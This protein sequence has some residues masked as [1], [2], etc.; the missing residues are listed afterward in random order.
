MILGGLAIGVVQVVGTVKASAAGSPNLTVTKTGDAQTLLGAP[1]AYSIK[2]CN[3]SGPD[4]FNGSIRDVLP[5]GV[6]LVSGTPAPTSV[7]TDAPGAGQ[8]TLLWDNY[9]DLPTGSCMSVS[10]TALAD[11]TAHPVGDTVT[12]TAN[13]YVNTNV[14]N[15]VKFDASGNPIASSYTGSGTDATATTGITAY[16]LTK[17]GP[18]EFMRG[19]HLESQLYTLTLANNP[20]TPTDSFVVDDYLPPNLELLGCKAG[21]NTTVAAEYTGAVAL[22]GAVCTYTGPLTVSSV[23]VETI[24]NTGLSLTALGNATGPFTPGTTHVRW[25]FA[26]S[27]PGGG[28]QTITYR[29]GIP[30]FE[31][32]PFTGVIP[33]IASGNQSTNL[34]NNTGSETNESATEPAVVNRSYSSGVYSGPIKAPTSNPLLNAASSTASA[35]DFAIQKTTAG[36][37]VQ[38]AVITN[39]FSMQVSEYRQIASS[40][41]TDTLPDGQCPLGRTPAADP[42]CPYVAADVPTISV[43]GAAPIAAPYTSALETTTGANPANGSYILVWDKSTV[44]SLTLLPPDAKI[45][46]VFKSKVR[47]TYR[48]NGADANPILNGDAMTNNVTLSGVESKKTLTGATPG[49]QANGVTIFDDATAS[50]TGLLASIDKSVAVRTGTLA[51]GSNIALTGTAAGN[52][53]ANVPA[54]NYIPDLT[55]PNDVFGS[56]D[57]ACYKL[58]ANFPPNLGAAAVALSDF[59]PQGFQYIRGSTRPTS[60]NTVAVPTSSDPGATTYDPALSPAPAGPGTLS[61]DAASLSWSVGAV[62]NASEVMEVT[63]AVFLGPP[64]TARAGDLTANLLKMSLKNTAGDLFPL[65][66]QSDLVWKE[67]QLQVVKGV[68]TVNR[69]SGVPGGVTP[70]GADLGVNYKDTVAVQAGDKVTYRV[71]VQNDGNADASRTVLWDKLPAGISC[72]DVIPATISNGGSCTAAPFPHIVW[73]ATSNL[74]VGKNS[75]FGGTGSL[76]LTYA[77]TIPISVVSNVPYTNTA[78]IRQWEVATNSTSSF[79]FVPD[80]NLDPTAVGNT[81]YRNTETQDIATVVVLAPAPVKTVDKATATV[82]DTVTYTVITDLPLT[83]IYKPSLVD[84]VPANLTNVTWSAT[85]VEAAGTASPIDRTA[86]ISPA[87]G[88]GNSVSIVLPDPMNN[89]GRTPAYRLTLTVVGR[90]ANI[91]ANRGSPQTDIAN[92]ASFRWAMT[93]SASV[94][95]SNTSKV[96]TLVTEPTLTIVKTDNTSNPTHGVDGGTSVGYTLHITNTGNSAAYNIAVQDAAPAGVVPT[97]GSCAPTPCSVSG[98]TLTWTITGALA[99]GAA[100][101]LTYTATVVTPR[102]KVDLTNTATISSYRSNPTVNPDTRTYGPTTTTD[103][104][105]PI[106]SLGGT[107][108]VDR[109][110]SGVLS[111]GDPIIT[112]VTVTVTGTDILGNPVSVTTTT[113]LNGKYSFPALL[114]S[115]PAGYTITETQPVN[116]GDGA[117]NVGVTDAAGSPTVGNGATPNVVSAVVLTSGLTATAYNFGETPALLSGTVWV[118]LNRDGIVDGGEAGRLTGVTVALTGTAADGTAVTRSTTTSGDGTYSFGSIA[119]PAGPLPAGTYTISETQPVG[120]GSSTPNNLTSVVVPAGAAVP[121]KNFGETLASIAGNVYVDKSNDGTI[122]AGE[123]GIGLVTVALTGTDI[124]G[125]T[126]SKTTTTA[127][128]G[129]YIFANLL[130]GTYTVT[131]TQPSAWTD[132]LDAVGTAG[133][134]AANDA[135]SA[136]ALGGGVQATDYN[137]GERGAVLSGVVYIDRDRAGGLSTGDPGL[138]GVTITLKD[139][140]GNVVA[141]TTTQADGTYGF[142]HLPKGDY[143]I[144]E[145]QPTGYGTS[146]P[147]TIAVSLPLAGLTN[148]NFGETASTLAGFVYLDKNG[149]LSRTASD[150]PILGVTITL[151]GTD[152]NGLAVTRTVTT[153]VDGSYSFI[154]L[155]SGT[156]AISETQPTAWG[157]SADQLGS[158]PTTPG[159]VGPDTFT[160]ITL[161]TAQDGINYNFGEKGASV[162][163]TVFVDT[164]RDGTLGAAETGLSGVTITLT[165]TDSDGNSISLT[166]ITG[167]TGTY[168]FANLPASSASGYTLT[169]TQPSGYGSSTPNLIG[170]VAV[171]AGASITGQNFGE[172]TSRLAGVV[173]NDLSNDGTQQSSEPGIAGT[174]ITLTGVDALGNTVTRT[175]TT[176][177]NGS[178]SFGGTTDPA[179]ILLSGTYTVTETQPV[180]WNDGLDTVGSSG[181]TAANDATSAIALGSGVAATGYD[182]GERGATLS[183]TVFYDANRNATLDGEQGIGSVVITLKDGAGIV[184][185]TTTTASNG[186]YFFANLPA[187]AYTMEETQP[188]GYGSSTSNT[189][190]VT[191]PLTGLANQNF[192]E[193]LS[194]LSGHVDLDRD[195]SDTRTAPDT[196]IGGVTVTLTGTDANGSGVTRTTTTLADGTYLFA[197]LLSGTYT[198]TESQ[199]QAWGDGTDAL[200][201][202]TTGAGTLGND[203]LSSIT[204]GTTEDGLGYNFLER[205][206]TLLGLVFV[207]VNR[208]GIRDAADTG[209]VNGVVITLTGTDI[210]GNAVTLTTTSGTDGSYAFTNLAAAGSGG[211]KLTESQPNGYGS[212]TS[213]VIGSIAVSAGGTVADQNFGESTS[214]LAGSVYVDVNDNGVRDAS[215][216]GV[217]GVTVTLTGTDAAGTEISRTAT[218]GTDGTYSFGTTLDP[219]GP[220][221]GGRYTIAE[222]QP[223]NYRDGKDAV[224]TA[225]G[226]LGP[227]SVTSIGLGGGLDGT[228]YNFGELTTGLAGVVFVDDN[229]DGAR[230]TTEGG[231]IAGVAVTLKGSSGTV[232]AT[233]TTL[234]DGSYFFPGLTTGNYTVEIVAPTGYGTSTPISQ[235]AVVPTAGLANVDFGVTGSTLGGRVFEDSNNDGVS[236]PSKVGIGG[237]TITLTGTDVAGNP[238]NLTTVTATNGSYLFSN[239]VA[240]TYAVTETQPSAYVDG[241]DAAGTSGGTVGSDTVTAITLAAATDATGYT[242]GETTNSTLAGTVFHDTNG[243]GAISAGDSGLGGVTITLTGVDSAGNL[244]VRTTTTDPNGTYQ[245]ADVPPGTYSVIETQ[246]EGYGS[247]TPNTLSNVVVPSNGLTQLNF[248]ET[249]ASLAGHAFVDS[250][251]SGDLGSGEVGI[252][253]VAVTLTGTQTNGTTVT[254]TV[255]T[256]SDGS[257]VFADLLAGT[258]TVTETQPT[259]WNDGLDHVGSSAGTLAN[260]KISAISLAGGTNAVGY[261]FG[262]RGANLSGVVFADA[263]TDGVKAGTD[264][265]LAGVTVRLLDGAGNVLATAVTAS[266]GSYTFTNIAAGNYSISEVQPNG[267]GSS[268]PNTIAITLPVAGL[269]NQNFGETLSSLAGV[270]YHDDS[271]DGVRN[272]GEQGLGGVVITLTGTDATGATVTKTTTTANDGTYIFPSLLAGTYTVTET[273]PAAFVNGITTA[274]S[275]GGIVSANSISNVGLGAGSNATSYNFGE[276]GSPVTGHVYLDKNR[277]GT[278]SSGEI[279][280]VGVVITLFDSSGISV[281]TTTTASDG[282]YSFAPVPSGNYSLVETQPA[283]FGSSTPNTLTVSVPVAGL[284]NQDFG[285]TAASLSGIVAN[286]GDASGTLGSADTGIVGVTVTL[287]DGSGAIVATATTMADGSYRFDNLPAG[288]YSVIETQP[289]TWADGVDLVGTSGGVASVN[290]TISAI[291]LAAAADAIGYNFLELGA[292]IS[293]AVNIAPS[294]SPV[295]AVTITL[296]DATGTVVATATTQADGS[297]SFANLPLG[298]YTVVEAQ[299]NG[300]GSTTPDS[301]PVVLIAAGRLVN[302]TETLAA[303]RGSVFHDADNDGVLGTT[304]VGIVGVTV[305]LTGTD[306]NGLAVSRTAVTGSDGTYSFSDLVAGAY[307]VIETQPAVYLDGRDSPGTA[308][309]NAAVDSQLDTIGFVGLPAGL[310]ASMYNFGELKPASI[311]G[312]H[313]VDTNNNG[314]VDAGEAPQSGVIV[315]LNGFNDLGAVVTLTKTTAS[316]GSYSFANLRPG[317]Y[318]LTQTEPTGLFDGKET[319]GLTGGIVDNTQV[320]NTIKAVPLAS[321]QDDSGNNFGDLVPSSVG[322]FVFWDVNAD[323]IQGASE[324]GIG[325]VVV[326]LTGS[327]DFGQPVSLTTITAPNGTYV[328]EGLRPGTYQATFVPPAGLVIT[329]PNAGVPGQN[330]VADASGRALVVV[331]SEVHFTAVDVGMYRPAVIRDRVILDVNRSGTADPGEVGVAGVTV[332]LWG[333]GPDGVLGT[334]DDIVLGTAVTAANGDFSFTVSSGQSY[335]AFIQK[336]DKL[337]LVTGERLYALD[338]NGQQTSVSSSLLVQPQIRSLPRTGSE[339]RPILGL[340]AVAV[341]GGSALVLLSRRRRRPLPA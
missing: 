238:V 287:R 76:T 19:V 265:G 155:L 146:T 157:D 105:Y 259:S 97:A 313:Y 142:A 186:T 152:A 109:D 94:D 78:G 165:G 183:G 270:V 211:Y 236:T 288:T 307:T 96:D 269:T 143:T 254:K 213:N 60:Q 194:S 47:T 124:N 334:A 310:D 198:L 185:A 229:R 44:A 319:A 30:L 53:C 202:G 218:T 228:A 82:G 247:S 169:E 159:L 306:V 83:T 117:V 72:A 181:G 116:W 184:V 101:D 242:F 61:A 91:A 154:D 119:D 291:V 261:D 56:G 45:T 222:T 312:V 108:Y 95:Q 232:V 110:A 208:D 296:L 327:D 227:D 88:T 150:A 84:T 205:G 266:D 57:I 3:S 107:V 314:L 189:L 22:P 308:G 131:E 41:V 75:S 305:T 33:T 129:T 18:G 201:T 318:T 199:P 23:Q 250:N 244:I 21:D 147:N 134:T 178:Y 335:R 264:A 231:R 333:P 1:A 85:L 180:G 177:T 32:R 170:S 225:G 5:A 190:S 235:A 273:Q 77:V 175:T 16:K 127:A 125:V 153:A 14:R 15:I 324:P 251:N 74:S 325:G 323:G 328:F 103:T 289:S 176:A 87:S 100:V 122:Q 304:E 73:P 128:D 303:L 132:G 93:S 341:V 6:T 138:G 49:T 164:S 9:Q 193:T 219:D 99:A 69:P 295:A 140:L 54:V 280:V 31:N 2:A 249:L 330:S 278:L 68:K 293:G 209:R 252:I 233:T 171:A 226:T 40:V 220:L 12:D 262:E 281:A 248:G 268:T 239:V 65:R 260:D 317:R 188:L 311:S 285:D 86:L 301:V 340:G 191:L 332:T 271:N 42:Q 38:G 24:G 114:P 133:G 197:N 20:T 302:F 322:D 206:A 27:L 64:N 253:G 58:R 210:D 297:Y 279:G 207:D 158:G 113:G 234:A 71:D 212:S 126:V 51:S 204:L 104:V 286:D 240:G 192:G 25:T 267:Y 7:L 241:K 46:M 67:A 336:V 144:E 66:A 221:L 256:G 39:T 160:A 237:V 263:N 283:A 246:P 298:N 277:D 79:V 28:I 89:S 216:Q 179:G 70:Y 120:Y 215:E 36:A 320:A 187:G 224:G 223:A 162:G 203:T 275:A 130:A 37:V 43:N 8:T 217:A 255:L 4:A 81:S 151:S 315:T 339:P 214:T 276:L 59:L 309:G 156:Y 50:I 137:F 92:V 35:E 331:T 284:F 166:T 338:A 257:Y 102:P 48:Q 245:F 118:D 161:G 98:Q 316:D 290:D 173:Y 121:N 167:I 274:G 34:D 11:P 52:V 139:A 196:P 111:T 243:D 163:G 272:S 123:P 174:T 141:T 300:Y 55:P 321:G 258:Y 29:A 10:Y 13:A 115:N 282:S 26:G 106:V 299:P 112:G 17:A 182:F 294:G 200:G 292:T 145:T 62:G 329:R 63:I 80:N 168:S 136:I 230:A 326:T 149:D 172:I 90:V 195:V 337:L 135:T 148:Q